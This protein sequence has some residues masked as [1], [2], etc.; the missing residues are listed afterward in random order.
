MELWEGL[1]KQE[2][3]RVITDEPEVFQTLPE[4]EWYQEPLQPLYKKYSLE[5]ILQN[6]LERRV[7]LP[8]GG[9]LVIEQTEAFVAVDVNSGK[10]RGER[11]PDEFYY[12]VN[13]EAAREIARQLRLRNLS[14]TILIDFI[15][16]K[17]KGVTDRLLRELQRRFLDDPVRTQAIDV[18]RLNITEATRQKVRRA[19]WEQVM[20]W[21]QK[22]V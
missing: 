2:P 19:L 3:A 15:N 8:S 10:R 7:P 20:L 5:N 17:D 18:T 12:R 21:E 11:L 13:E 4:A 22:D 9:F 6:A 16:M 1:P 14:G